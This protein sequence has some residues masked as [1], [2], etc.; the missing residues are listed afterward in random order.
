M[1]AAVWHDLSRELD[2]WGADGRTANVWLR[3]DDAVA[4]SLSLDRLLD[5]A[6]SVPLA[7]AVIP[8]LMEA[9]LAAR[10]E[11]CGTIDI[12]P[13]GFRHRNHE[14]EGSKKCEFGAARD[15]TDAIAEISKAGNILANAFGER[16]V[17]L[18]VPPWNRIAPAIAEAAIGSAGMAGISTYNDRSK[19]AALPGLNTH[20]DLL[21]WGWKKSTG[22]AR[23]AGSDACL[24]GLV[25]A[26]N[27][28]RTGAG[29]IDC[30]EAV[31]ILTH[32]LE[33]DGPTWDFLDRLIET[34]SG[35]PAVH[36]TAARDAI[37][38]GRSSTRTSA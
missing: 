7:L 28:R 32:H 38:P 18:F 30:E 22:T 20:V 35:H 5:A 24:K 8:D 17:P 12:L 3:D 31:G 4:P 33:H 34:L 6:K 13:H 16:F 23:F 19:D 15:A 2:A 29:N 25:G 37:R 1:T 14:P 9:D 21:D 10:I 26:L 27:G 36:W 11:A